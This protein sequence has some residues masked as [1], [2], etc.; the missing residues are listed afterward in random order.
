[1]PD[2][3]DIFTQLTNLPENSASFEGGAALNTGDLRRKFALDKAVREINPNRDTLFTLLNMLGRKNTDSSEFKYIEKRNAQHRRYVHVVKHGTTEGGMVSNDA[4]LPASVQTEGSEIWLQVGTDYKYNGN[5][6]NKIGQANKKIDVGDDGTRPRFIL[7]DSLLKV[8]TTTNAGGSD[9]DNPKPT[10]YMTIHVHDVKPT[11]NF[12]NVRGTVVR[13]TTARELMSFES[14]SPVTEVYDK[15]IATRLEGMRSYISGSAFKRGS[16]MPGTWG[17]QPFS[18]AYGYTEIFKTKLSMD[19][20]SITEV[21][22]YSPS[23]FQRLW[24]EKLLEHKRDISQA[25]WN[26]R[27]V[28][29]NGVRYTQGIIDFIVNYANMFTLD[30]STAN[31]DTFLEILSQ[32]YDPRYNNEKPTIWFADTATYN[33][34]HKISG[35]YANNLDAHAQLRGDISF[36]KQVS[37]GGVKMSIIDTSAGRIKL[38]REINLDGSPVKIA[39]VNMKSAKYRPLVGNGNNRDTAAYINVESLESNGVDRTTDLIQ[40]EAGLEISHPE[41]FIALI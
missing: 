23:E 41:S 33:W 38:V 29:V 12:V 10:D 40:T 25:L 8:N 34:M 28:E 1:M 21:L 32:F 9:A 13:P 18:S 15:P 22:K 36:N 26:G 6:V 2:M 16:G 20:T 35:Y 27:Q 31:A 24:S 14:D 37:F 17:D 3:I 5:I 19:N 30:L 4:T 39:G 11:G 7:E